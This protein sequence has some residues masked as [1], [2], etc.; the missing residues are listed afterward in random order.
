MLK[1]KMEAS[2]VKR[3]R[4]YLTKPNLARKYNEGQGNQICTCS[5]VEF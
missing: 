4:L 5:L 1:T 3:E 2:N